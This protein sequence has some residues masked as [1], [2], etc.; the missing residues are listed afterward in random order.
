MEEDEEAEES[1]AQT[2]LNMVATVILHVVLAIA[3]S[4]QGKKQ[5]LTRRR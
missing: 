3:R 5:T 1:A 2:K 4:R